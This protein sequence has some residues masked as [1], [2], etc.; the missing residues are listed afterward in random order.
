MFFPRGLRSRLLSTIRLGLGWVGLGAVMLCFMLC[1]V[2][3]R[4][5]YVRFGSAER[6]VCVRVRGL[7]R[8][9]LW[10]LKL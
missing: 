7:D 5:C 2:M 1:Y 10:I 3:L 9:E 6:V 8:T 4:L